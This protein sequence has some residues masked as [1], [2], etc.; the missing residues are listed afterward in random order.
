[1]THEQYMN[2]LTSQRLDALVNALVSGNLNAQVT[3]AI[4]QTTTAY[5]NGVAALGQYGPGHSAPN[6]VS[7]PGAT[8]VANQTGSQT[9]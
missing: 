3:A 1:M 4:Q 5:Y 6:P 2:F 9:S 8:G 7:L